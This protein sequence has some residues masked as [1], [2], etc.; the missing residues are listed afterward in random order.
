MRKE[1]L[2]SVLGAGILLF[3][4]FA[5]LT[6]FNG[7][8]HALSQFGEIWYL[9]I[10]LAA[11]FGA[12]IGLYTYTKN[13][14]KAASCKKE[15]AAS[16]TVSTG[17]MVACCIHHAADVLPFVGLSGT[18]IFFADYQSFFLV[19]GILSNVIGITMMLGI[20]Q[21]HNLYKKG[22]FI[23]QAMQFDMKTARNAAVV[24]SV[25]F[26]VMLA[27]TQYSFFYSG[28]QSKINLDS[29]VSDENSLSVEVKPAM[30]DGSVE[31]FISMNTHQ[32]NLEYDLEKISTLEDD[33][34]NIYAPVWSGSPPGG[35]HR[36]GT[37]TFSGINKANKLTLKIKDLYGADR[38]F[39]WDL[40]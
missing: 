35:H 20:I 14:A 36:S 26:L 32:G 7:F 13:Y 31:F 4:Y 37:L 28:E 17:S 5:V 24:F 10:P 6:T 21:K 38:I 16:G 39:E 3:V 8:D 33:K 27:F 23:A 1:I 19:L 34:G 15:F 40:T 18:L 22:S 9:I 12:Q 2:Y 29:Q 30:F 11:G 25:V